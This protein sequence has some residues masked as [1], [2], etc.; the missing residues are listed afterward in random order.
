MPRSPYP[1]NAQLLHQPTCYMC[2]FC[3]PYQMGKEGYVSFTQLNTTTHSLFLPEVWLK[4]KSLCCP[5]LYISLGH[6]HLLSFHSPK[7]ITASNKTFFFFEWISHKSDR[8]ADRPLF[9]ISS[10]QKNGSGI[11]SPTTLQ[12]LLARTTSRNITFQGLSLQLFASLA[13]LR[14]NDCHESHALETP[15]SETWKELTSQDWHQTIITVGSKFRRQKCYGPLVVSWA[16][17]ADFFVEGT[18]AETSIKIGKG[19]RC[20]NKRM[21]IRTRAFSY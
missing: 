18:M 6:K 5:S 2:L 11:P 1:N 14:L 8:A 13:R 15:L 12:P 21:Q 20:Q 19:C 10:E 3:A 7:K 17:P 9:C 4:C 16:I